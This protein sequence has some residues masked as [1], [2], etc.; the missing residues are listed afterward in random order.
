MLQRVVRS[1]LA[2]CLANPGSLTAFARSA[3]S[4]LSASFIRSPSVEKNY[5]PAFD[6]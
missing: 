4:L 5:N 3:L 2:T 1:F 6:H